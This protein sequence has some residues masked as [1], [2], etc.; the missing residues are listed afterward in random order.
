MKLKDIIVNN[1]T[2]PLTGSEYLKVL[3]N[4]V[5]DVNAA[6]TYGTSYTDKRIVSLDY[7]QDMWEATRVE[8]KQGYFQTGTGAEG[9]YINLN[10][11]NGDCL[12]SRNYLG[13]NATYQILVTN[14]P[15]GKGLI[16]RVDLFGNTTLTFGGSTNVVLVSESVA[17]SYYLGFVSWIQRPSFAAARS[18]IDLVGVKKAVVPNVDLT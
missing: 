11:E 8:G 9:N 10:Y 2:Y 5:I 12:A 3:T 6:E 4:G 14:L 16:A 1:F 17:G 15:P 18:C 13:N 7:L